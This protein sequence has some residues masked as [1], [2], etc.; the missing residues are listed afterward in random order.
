MEHQHLLI[1]YLYYI[2]LILAFIITIISQLIE[3]VII[4]SAVIV[5]TNMYILVRGTMYISLNISIG[6]RLPEWP[7][8]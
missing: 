7:S 5:H 4:S 8:G 3:H 6:Y 1:I 2:N